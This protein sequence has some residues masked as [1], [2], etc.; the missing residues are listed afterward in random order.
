MKILIT[1][2]AG[3]IGSNFI[4]YLFKKYPDY[5]IVNLDKL[6][7]AGNLDNLKGIEN[8]P[9][10]EFI[11]GDICDTTLVNDVMK[12]GIGAIIN[13]AAESHV[14]RSIQDPGNFIKTDVLGTHLLLAA[15]RTHDIERYVQ[16]STDEVYGDIEPGQ[17]SKEEDALHPSSPYSA[18]KAGGD[19][20][21]L[22][23]VRTYAVPA[24]ITRCTN[25]YGPYQ[26]P[27]K[28][29]P[30]FITNAIENKPLPIYG[31]GKQIRDWMHVEDHCRG[32]D[33]VLHEGKIGEIYN[34]G[35]N[36]EKEWTNLEITDKILKFLDKPS[37]LKRFV[38][39]RAGH[40]RRYAVDCSKIKSLGWKREIDLEEGLQKMVQWYQEN[41]WWWKKL[42][43]GEFSE[44][45][46]KQ[47]GSS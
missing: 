14:D 31:D 24:I 39:D 41:E 46:Q 26:Y 22:S 36:Q 16:I 29:I 17:Y 2:G 5:S 21:I 3:F 43:Q 30:L 4:H 47:Y 38:K 28:V 25:N 19:L 27:E 20:Q 13:F 34:I 42:K 15:A 7:Y 35:A 40:D 32:I 33:L 6:T 44:Y 9:R 8:D 18:S 45:Y 10:Y 37:D 11:R 23:A 12:K 1:G